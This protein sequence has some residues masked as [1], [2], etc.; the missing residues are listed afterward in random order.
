MYSIYT[1]L[2]AGFIAVNYLNRNKKSKI[3]VNNC[4]RNY[5]LI[6]DKKQ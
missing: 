1:W 6:R 4:L 3:A 5:K 2:Q